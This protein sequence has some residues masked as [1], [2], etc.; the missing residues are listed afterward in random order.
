MAASMPTPAESRELTVR[1][2]R[3][4][5]A[6]ELAALEQAGPF[7][8]AHA[9][10]AL[11]LLEDD[12]AAAAEALPRAELWVATCSDE[13]RTARAALGADAGESD[14]EE[15]QEGAA[16]GDGGDKEGGGVRTRSQNRRDR[17]TTAGRAL[18]EARAALKLAKAELHRLH[19]ARREC[20]DQWLAHHGAQMEAARAHLAHLRASH[21][22]AAD[23]VFDEQR[24]ARQTAENDQ[25]ERA[26]RLA[27]ASLARRP[28]ATPEDIV[29]RILGDPAPQSPDPLTPAERA[30]MSWHTISAVNRSADDI[31]EHL[32]SID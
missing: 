11:Q 31:V 5:A 16:E 25:A 20:K 32:R 26:A 6:H 30:K 4:A 27:R 24:I 29:A 15:E 7:G 19:G 3:D 12:V 14:E 13:L 9:R 8:S 18:S 1:A 22:R 23:A 21:Q 10:A 2:E 28:R 17:V